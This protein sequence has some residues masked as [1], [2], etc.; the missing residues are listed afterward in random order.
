[1]SF[2]KSLRDG[3]VG[4]IE[5]FLDYAEE[6]TPD[7]EKFAPREYLEEEVHPRQLVQGDKVRVEEYT[8][9]DIRTVIEGTVFTVDKRNELVLLMEN[10]YMFRWSEARFFYQENTSAASR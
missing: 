9:A 10:N 4:S 5:K 7:L 6:R 8:D 2:L 3:A 1:M